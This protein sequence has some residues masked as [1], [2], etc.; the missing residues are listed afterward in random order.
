MQ[1][2]CHI[3]GFPLRGLILPPL[4][5]LCLDWWE[6]LGWG[7]VMETFV[8][9]LEHRHKLHFELTYLKNELDFTAYCFSDSFFLC[10]FTQQK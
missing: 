1:S 6:A 7:G 3:V 8:E 9:C 5:A 2:S 4:V 10:A